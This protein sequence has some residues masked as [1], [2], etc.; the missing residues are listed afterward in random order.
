M[1]Q[2]T[3]L[4]DTTTADLP[5]RSVPARR[6]GRPSR[7]AAGKLEALVLDI[8][9]ECFLRD[10]Y[11]ATTIEA[12]AARARISKRTLYSRHRDK[13]ALF[14]AVVRRLID[15][16]LPSFQAAVDAPA[17]LPE[18]LRAA[19]RRVLAL[20]LTPEALALNRLLIAETGRFPELSAMLFAAGAGAGRARLAGLLATHFP[21][22]AEADIAFAAEQFMH[23][24]LAGPQQRALG[25]GAPLGPEELEAWLGRAVRL[26]LAGLNEILGQP[27]A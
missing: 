23:L 1:G 22:A 3:T 15:G 2:I 6:G 7:E 10:G 27:P 8:A 9:A 13:A 16:W 12:I 20:G 5:M 25:L 17:S 21:G 4:A 24:V 14:G 18:A 26:F 11:A 19:A